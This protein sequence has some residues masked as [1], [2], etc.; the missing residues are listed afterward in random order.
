MTDYTEIAEQEN[1]APRDP[2][3]HMTYA[4]LFTEF[5]KRLDELQ[6]HPA[7]AGAED[8]GDYVDTI[9]R[10]LSFRPR[11]HMPIERDAYE[12]LHGKEAAD[13]LRAWDKQQEEK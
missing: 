8:L 4:T 12:V 1:W 5:S 6:E 13:A 3:W 7:F 9:S 11:T 10:L 2:N